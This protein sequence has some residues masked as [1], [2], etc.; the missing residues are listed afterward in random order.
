MKAFVHLIAVL[1]VAGLSFPYSAHAEVD[2]LRCYK[3]KDSLNLKGIVGI[4]TAQVAGQGPRHSWQGL[5]EARSKFADV[6]QSPS[7]PIWVGFRVPCRA[8][9][10]TLGFCR[11]AACS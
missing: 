7:V 6:P 1:A 11:P 9:W 8:D 5:P 4:D 3:I 10:E 2:H